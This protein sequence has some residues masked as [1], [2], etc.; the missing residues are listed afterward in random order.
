MFKNKYLYLFL[1]LIFFFF[2]LSYRL[3]Q[4]PM[5]L[6]VDESAF[7]WN[8]AL[9]SRNGHDQ[10]GKFLPLFV[11]SIHNSDWRQPWTQYY[12][13]LFFKIFGISIYNLRLSSV[14]LILFSSFL[15]YKLVTKL[16]NWKY[17][18][19]SVFLFTC[20]P[21]IFM[22]SHLGLDNIMPIPFTLIWL[23]NLFNYQQQK[24]SKSLIYAALALGASFYSYKGMRAVVP[25]WSILS[26]LYILFLQY[27]AKINLFKLIK[28]TFPF[29]IS[30][31]PFFFIIP[32]L[33]HLYPG[34]IFGGARPKLD[35]IYTLIYDYFSHFDLTFL[36][37]KGD[38]LLFHSTQK[39]GMMLLATA[40]LFLIGLYQTIR[41]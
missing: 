32:Y 7:G 33:S 41:R 5:G 37:I 9:L 34:A 8:A 36:Y 28:Y 39:H 13:T 1:S 22:H 31:L 26:V 21:V 24:K 29:V 11:S 4:V 6:T 12:I 38:A 16:F 27:K 18:L 23:I 14:V 35:E 3:T 15:L 19:V 25:I 20:T 17:A 40:P 10:N 2:L 30:I